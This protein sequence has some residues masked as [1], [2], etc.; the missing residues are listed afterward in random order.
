VTHTLESSDDGVDLVVT[1]DWNHAAEKAILGGQANGLVLNYARGYRSRDLAFLAGLPIRRLHLIDRSVVDLTPVSSLAT[2]LISLRVQTD[3]RAE[4]AL[5]DLPSLRILSAAWSQV[6]A[7]IA[8]AKHLERLFLTSYDETD[9]GPLSIVRNL[10][11]LVLKDRPRLQTLD[12]MEY[13][14]W[15]SEFGAHTASRLRDIDAVSRQSSPMLQSFQLSSTRM[16][17]SLESIRMCQGL[18]F[19]EFSECGELASLTPLRDLQQLERIYLYGST[20]VLDNDLSPI[21]GLPRLHD[22]RMQS[23]REYR[24]SVQEIQESIARR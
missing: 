11:S 2:H 19:L 14:P 23:R 7:S 20:R 5:D 8:F 4:I 3:P 24:P 1:G 13:L 9:L 21:R 15:L 12:G 6:R 10:T 18:R 17:V 16:V 22:F